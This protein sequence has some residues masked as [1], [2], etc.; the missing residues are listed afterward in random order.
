MDVASVEKKQLYERLMSGSID[1]VVLDMKEKSTMHFVKK[2]VFDY[3]HELKELNVEPLKLIDHNTG[4]E[5]LV[6]AEINDD[7]ENRNFHC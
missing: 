3:F 6:W 1:E 4:V 5:L 2:L 7:D